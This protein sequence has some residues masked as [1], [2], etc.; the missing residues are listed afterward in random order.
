MNW[1]LLAL[2]AC[3]EKGSDTAEH[4]E[5]T[6]SIDT[7]TV[8]TNED[9]EVIGTGEDA[10]GDGYAE[11]VDC[12]ESNAS[13][14]PDA[15]DWPEDGVD[16]D[17]QNGDQTLVPAGRDLYNA[18]FDIQSDGMPVD[19]SDLGDALQWQEAGSEIVTV[20]GLATG[21]TFQGHSSGGGAL[22]IWGD[23][24]ANFYGNGE[25]LVYQQFLPVDVWEP[26][27][28]VYWFDAWAWIDE[29]EVLENQATFSIGIRCYR[30]S[31]GAWTLLSEQKSVALTAESATNEWIHVWSKV[32]CP[33][34]TN[35][36]RTFVLFQQNTIGTESLDHGAVYVDD[37]QFGVIE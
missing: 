24:G 20:A 22:K 10:D 12:D 36:V 1:I 33:D 4:F 11:S 28:K 5:N 14:H 16:Q 25:S 19:W 34:T 35:V 6:D 23:Y 8:D 29:S 27:N 15:V 2:V 13:I 37:A 30:E 7:S 18:A 3:G 32:E 21:L 26:A 31:M 17:C 9:A